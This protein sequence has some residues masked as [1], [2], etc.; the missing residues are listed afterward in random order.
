MWPREQPE[1][2]ATGVDTLERARGHSVGVKNEH[3]IKSVNW[4]KIAQLEDGVANGWRWESARDESPERDCPVW[5]QKKN[6]KEKLSDTEE[7]F[8]GSHL[9]PPGALEQRQGEGHQWQTD[10]PSYTQTMDTQTTHSPYT[11]TTDIHTRTDID[12]CTHHTQ[13]H[14]NT[15]GTHAHTDTFHIHG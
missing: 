10:R 11:Q 2:S 1:G 3:D 4:S 9:C 5:T 7:R 6:V 14:T 13:T 15:A 12:K 8:T